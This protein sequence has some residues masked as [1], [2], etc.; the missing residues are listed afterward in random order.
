M[1]QAIEIDGESNEL[2]TARAKARAEKDFARSD[3]LRDVL[4]ARKIKVIDGPDG[5]SWEA[6]P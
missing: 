2:L 4:L 1:N 6:I 5:Q 3:E